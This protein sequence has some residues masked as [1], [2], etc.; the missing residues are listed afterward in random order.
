MCPSAPP[1]SFF[2][3]FTDTNINLNLYIFRFKMYS[4][5]GPSVPLYPN[6]FVER[7]KILDS[8]PQYCFSRSFYGLLREWF[9][10]DGDCPFIMLIKINFI[11]SLQA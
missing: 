3:I 8:H 4:A 10:R 9:N 7:D 11:K 6:F 2:F 1:C 5:S